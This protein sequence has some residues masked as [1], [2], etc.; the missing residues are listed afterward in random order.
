MPPAAFR[1]DAEQDTYRCPQG[2]S[3]GVDWAAD[4]TATRAAL[5]AIWNAGDRRQ[6]VAESADDQL[7]GG[8]SVSSVRR[9]SGAGPHVR[10]LGWRGPGVWRGG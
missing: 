6:L 9:A 4:G 3:L 1:Y 10:A 2:R 5:E 8:R 7:D